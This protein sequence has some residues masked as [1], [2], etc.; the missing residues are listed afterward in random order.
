MNIVD[1][2]DSQTDINRLQEIIQYHLQVLYDEVAKES[3]REQVYKFMLNHFDFGVNFEY[4]ENPKVS[5]V[6]SA[7]N[8]FAMTAALLHSIK[9]NTQDIEY[10]VIIADDNSNDKTTQIDDIFKNVKR[11]VN[12]TGHEGFIYNVNNAVSKARGEYILLINNDMITFPDYLKELLNVIESDN[13]IGIAGSKTLNTDAECMECG[14][15]LKKDGNIIFMGKQEPFDYMDN[16]NYIDCDYCSGC[17][18]LF[19]RDVFEKAG[20]FD[21][22]FAPAYYEDSD[23]AFNLKHNFGLK[24]VCVPRSKI[25]HFRSMSYKNVAGISDIIERNRIYFSQKWGKYITDSAAE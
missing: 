20:K 23:F 24:S 15:K 12:N 22:K 2:I 8:N 17:A 13:S 14:V 4:F 9:R 11:I 10:E 21:T 1:I 7:K 19:R 6:I 5:I 25:F 16:V 3:Y 18:I